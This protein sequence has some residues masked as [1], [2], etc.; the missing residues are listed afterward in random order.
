M[1]LNTPTTGART[2]RMI[3][4]FWQSREGLFYT[5]WYPLTVMLR[6][7]LPGSRYFPL[8]TNFNMSS[9]NLLTFDGSVLSGI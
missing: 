6:D 3:A 4:K 1:T 8:L 2:L 9:P 7:A 5:E